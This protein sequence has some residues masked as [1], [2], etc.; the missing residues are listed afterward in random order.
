[1]YPTS[2]T[3]GELSTRSSWRPIPSGTITLSRGL[4]V[5]RAVRAVIESTTSARFIHDKLERLGWDVLI[6]DA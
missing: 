2:L 5:T 1:M 3:P 4:D 6:A